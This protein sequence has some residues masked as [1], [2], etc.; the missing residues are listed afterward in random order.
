MSKDDCAWLKVRSRWI[1][2]K[3]PKAL[4]NMSTGS[5]P[6]HEAAL[7]VFRQAATAIADWAKGEDNAASQQPAALQLVFD[8]IHLP[9][10]QAH[11]NQ[12][13]CRPASPLKIHGDEQTPR[14]PYASRDRPTDFTSIKAEICKAAKDLDWE[15][16]SQLM[17]FLEVYGSHLSWG[18]SNSDIAIIDQ[19]K[20]DAAIAAALAA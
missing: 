11:P 6:S 7:Q 15:N 8:R 4:P 5:L 17:M 10:G 18:N 2:S 14:I 13:N 3:A 19:A 12:S 20:S 1:P 9:N 16:L